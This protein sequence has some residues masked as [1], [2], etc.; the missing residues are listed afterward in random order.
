MLPD[1]K[2]VHSLEFIFLMKPDTQTPLST[3][4]L[5]LVKLFDKQYWFQNEV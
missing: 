4:R 3:I 2:L 1:K 5:I